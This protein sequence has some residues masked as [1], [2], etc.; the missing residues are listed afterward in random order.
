MDPNSFEAIQSLLSSGTLR[1]IES[2]D[3][4][5]FGFERGEC[6]GHAI[7]P[8][9]RGSMKLREHV[10]YVTSMPHTQWSPKLENVSPFLTFSQ[11][12][13]SSYTAV[14]HTT[15]TS[16]TDTTRSSGSRKDNEIPACNVAY[17][18]MCFSADE[19]YVLRVHEESEMTG[20]SANETQQEGLSPKAGQYKI[21]KYEWRREKETAMIEKKGE[22]KTSLPWILG[23][24]T[25]ME[26]GAILGEEEENRSAEE[27][28][29]TAASAV[30]RIEKEEGED[31]SSEYFIFVCAHVSR[32]K[33]CGYCGMV[34][35]DL[36]SRC[37]REEAEKRQ[38]DARIKAGTTASSN[39]SCGAAVPRIKVLPCSHVG[40]HIYAGNILV[41][42]RFGGV[43]Y[44]LFFPE[45]V[46]TLVTALLDDNGEVP[47]SLVKKVRG[48]VGASYAH[49]E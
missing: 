13:K 4:K 40:G 11:L 27:S 42:S 30:Q 10:F 37:I 32:D 22:E 36:L 28:K 43:A 39:S 17:D 25:C 14:H 34:L 9:L 12:V 6:T 38:A 41:Y 49:L 5:E 44:G 26:Q 46:R 2:L 47:S 24:L 31:H 1:D 18:P 35:V 45:D 29:K 23:K 7:P 8:K 20:Q 16:A 48:H 19:E 3:P 33:R 15:S 21:T